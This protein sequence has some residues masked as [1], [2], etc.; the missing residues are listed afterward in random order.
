MLKLVERTNLP[1]EDRM[2]LNFALGKAHGDI[3]DHDKA[4]S[5]L[6]DGNRL[7]KDELKY[8][9][10]SAREEFANIKSTFSENL[11]ALDVYKEPDG[12]KGQQPI[13]ILGMP[14][15]GT[16]LVEQILASHSQV[17]GAGELALL[18]QSVD[19]IEWNS[20]QLS[21]DQIQSIR[22]S[23]FSGLTKIEASERYI[24]DKMPSNFRWIGF[25]FAAIPEAK[26]IH[27]KRDACA[28]CWS[29]YKLYFPSKVSA[30]LMIFRRWLS[31]TICI[32]T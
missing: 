29:N 23:Y 20:T 14:R 27:V 8:E 7:R 22:M 24:T 9:I 17:Y 25:I 13:F 12:E 5:Y 2:H 26:I 18:R 6:F 19:T 11:P 10:S 1:D 31:T 16:T 4:F 15:S 3:G 32:S 28:T 21:S 30:S